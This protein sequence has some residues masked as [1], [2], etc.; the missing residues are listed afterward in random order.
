LI[1]YL[2]QIIVVA[3]LNQEADLAMNNP[4]LRAQLLAAWMTIKATSVL[5]RIRQWPWTNGKEIKL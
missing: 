1:A 2:A 5:K 3:T 4:T